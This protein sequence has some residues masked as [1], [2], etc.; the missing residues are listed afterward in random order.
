MIMEYSLHEEKVTESQPAD[1][2]TP[3][4]VGEKH[5]VGVHRE[6]KIIF[7]ENVMTLFTCRLLLN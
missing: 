5:S 3:E 6:V 4:T 2:L 1:V 7:A